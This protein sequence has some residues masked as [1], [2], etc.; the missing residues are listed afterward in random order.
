MK[1]AKMFAEIDDS[2]EDWIVL[3]KNKIDYHPILMEL[4]WN[5]SLSYLSIIYQLSINIYLSI[6]RYLSS[7]QKV[8]F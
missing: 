8:Y 1:G 5:D 6:K 7:P 2:N 4:V 3:N